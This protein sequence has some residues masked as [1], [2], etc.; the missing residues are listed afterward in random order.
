MGNKINVAE[1]LKD[2]PKGMELDCTKYS[3]VYFIGVD[4]CKKEPKIKLKVE[5]VGTWCSEL[6]LDKYGKE[7]SHPNAKCLIFPKGKTTWEG[8]HKPFKD[9]DIVISSLGSIH[10][11]KNSTTSYCYIDRLGLLDTSETTCVRVMRFATEEEKEKLFDAI[12]AKGYKWNADTKTLDKL[13][14]PKFKVGDKIKPIGS[15][16]YYII[17]DIKNDRYILKNN[18]FLKF[19]D[20]HTFE[21]LVEPKFKDGDVISANVNGNLWYGIYQKESNTRLYCY[22]SYSVATENVYLVDIYGMCLINDILEIRLATEEEKQKLFDAIKDKGYRWDA[23]TKALEKIIEPKFKVGDKIRHKENGIYCT[24]G[25]YS[26]GISA[27]CTNI[28]LAIT[29]KDLEHWELAPNKFDITTLKPFDKVLVREDNK[30]VWSTQFFERINNRL[31]DSFVCVGGWR[32]RQ[33]IPYEG[34]EHLLNT[35]NEPD[36]FYKTWS[37]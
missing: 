28:G 4:D 8:F 5:T 32:Y 29:S 10:I 16:R 31:K 21:V 13:T 1:L 27:Y 18:N 11:L 22:A 7:S 23:E 35:S 30:H 12:K 3:N 37:S 26:E 9:G 19:T 6:T 34:N 25:E 33:C 24:L 20:E 36:D 15:D 2:C 14:E 17:K